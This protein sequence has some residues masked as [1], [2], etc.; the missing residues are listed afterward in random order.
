[1][2]KKKQI[3]DLNSFGSPGMRPLVTVQEKKDLLDRNLSER[4]VTRAMEPWDTPLYPEDPQTWGLA[5][6]RKMLCLLAVNRSRD[7]WAWFLYQN[8][9]SSWYSPTVV[10]TPEG[11][12][13]GSSDFP[14]GGKI[15][16][17][18][19]NKKLREQNSYADSCINKPRGA[20]A[21][22]GLDLVRHHQHPA[23]LQAHGGLQT[24]PQGWRVFPK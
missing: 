18:L 12:P 10:E 20:E 19:S 24:D 1:M 2:K 16:N 13:P 15:M 11:G 21:R 17:N 8:R 6:L 22:S 9:A 4:A 14:G 23:T 7:A 5:D 3:T